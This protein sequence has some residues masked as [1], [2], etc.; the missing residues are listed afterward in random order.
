Q[1]A[2]DPS[3]WWLGLADG[4]PVGVLLIVASTEPPGWEVAYIG[5]VPEARRR[6][7]GRELM[8]QAL[9]EAR[10]AE[11]PELCLTVA[12]RNHPAWELYRS[13]GFVA[14]DRREVFLALW[15]SC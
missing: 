8:L 6:G 13:L 14:F 11:V 4:V 15:N 9:L 3:L 7:F 12:G 1:G 2:F 10:A 5:V